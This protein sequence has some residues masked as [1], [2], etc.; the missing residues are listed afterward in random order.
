VVLP[1][2]NSLFVEPPAMVTLVGAP[3][4]PAGTVTDKLP[5]G[6]VTVPPA[7]PI[8]MLLDLL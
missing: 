5:S 4:V 2:P 3:N 7:G 6:V 1:T 8:T